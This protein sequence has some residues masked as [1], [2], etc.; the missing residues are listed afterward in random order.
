M[1]PDRGMT[2][3]WFKNQKNLDE[4]FPELKEFQ[5]ALDLRF[6]ARCDVPKGVTS[7]EFDFGD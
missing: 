5:K 4:A 3:M 1:A 6:E 2:I 7:K